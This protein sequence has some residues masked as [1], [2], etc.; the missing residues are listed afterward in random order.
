MRIA[1]ALSL[2]GWYLATAVIP[3]GLA[4]AAR[5]VEAARFG[6]PE[7]TWWIVAAAA[8]PA[9]VAAAR[10]PRHVGAA[11]GAGLAVAAMYVVVTVAVYRLVFPMEA[12][13]VHAGVLLALLPAL[14]GAVAGHLIGRRFRDR[15][16]PGLVK[17]AVTGALI[18]LF[19]ALMM[20]GTMADAAQ[21]SAVEVTGPDLYALGPGQIVVP[22]A[23]RYT[24]LGDGDPPPDP[25]C[26]LARP[27][28]ADV[29]AEPL[30]V[31]PEEAGYDATPATKTI[32]DV[33]VAVAGIYGLTCSPTG[34]GTDYRLVRRQSISPVAD[35]V[36]RWPLPLIM[37]VGALPGLALVAGAVRR[38]RPE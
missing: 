27:G 13:P 12:H 38:S 20:P 4:A 21:F 6:G 28:A 33:D 24:L 11:I 3:L 34:D 26:R 23:A 10:L 15:P 5:P 16:E 25:G 29:P 35:S 36:M 22:A 18:A 37:L 32:A 17:A 19:G 7:L 9:A 14:V 30:T 2:V 8:L 31:Q 1:G